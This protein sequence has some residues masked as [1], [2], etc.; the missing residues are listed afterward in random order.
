VG[1]IVYDEQ[2]P[3]I[4]DP[5]LVKEM[6]A[7]VKIPCK[8]G[9][10]TDQVFNWIAENRIIAI[11]RNQWTDEKGGWASFTIMNE[12]ERMIFMLRWA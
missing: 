8:Y 6:D 5:E 3:Y 9:E 2:N 12:Q 1:V 7:T 10:Y 11:L 4:P